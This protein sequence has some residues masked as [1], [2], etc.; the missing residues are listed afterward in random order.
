MIWFPVLTIVLV[1]IVGL[2]LAGPKGVR[3][4]LV[5][6][7]FI[8]TGILVGLSPL[9][10]GAYGLL[11]AVFTLLTLLAV[12]SSR[13]VRLAR[14]GAYLLG[15]G[16]GGLVLL[17]SLVIRIKNIC[18]GYVVLPPGVNSYECYA[19]ETFAGVAAYAAIFLLGALML[20]QAGQRREA[21]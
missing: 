6:A 4:A 7:A 16:A 13:P 2:Y 11:L 5:I 14:I 15:G 10:L 19:P 17:L 12:P 9:E 20:Y 1:I 18:G 8:T 3:P 21:K